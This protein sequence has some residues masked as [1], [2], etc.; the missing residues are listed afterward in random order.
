M[1]NQVKNYLLFFLVLAVICLNTSFLWA[2]DCQDW[3][4]TNSRHVSASRAYTGTDGGCG[5]AAGGCNTSEA[6]TAYYAVGSDDYLGT[7]PNAVTVLRTEDGGQSYRRGACAATTEPTTLAYEAETA[8]IGNGV[9]ES[10]HPGYSGSGYVNYANEMGSYVEWTVNTSSSGNF[11]VTFRYA[12]GGTSSRPMDIIVNDDTQI[13]SQSFNATGTWAD[14][15]ELT[16]A[17]Y[18]DRGL[19]SI[20]AASSSSEGGPNLDKIDVAGNVV[21]TPE[22]TYTGLFVS[23]N[24]NDNNPGTISA[25]FKSITKAQSVASPGTTVYLRG[26]TYRGFRIAGSDANYNFVHNI[27]KSGIT[28]SAYPGETPVFDFTGTTTAKRVAAFHIAKGVNVTLIGFHV[29]GV[30]VGNNKQAECFRIEGNAKFEKM[31]CRD[32]QANG[33]YFTTDASGSCTNCDSYNN[34]GVGQSA[35]NTDGFGAHCRGEV[36]FRYCRAWNCSDDGYDCIA[37]YSRVTFDHCWVYNINSTGDGNGFK[38]GGWGTATPPASVPSHIVRY[39]LAANVKNSGFY[40]NHHPGKSADWTYNTAYNC[41]PD[42]NMLERVSTRNATDIPGTREVL[43]YNIAFG[44]TPTSNMNLPAANV[45]DNSWTKR[46]VTVTAAD[47]QSTDARQMI[48][49]RNADGSLPAITFMKL[50]NGSDLAGM[51][52]AP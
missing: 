42:F 46:G 27:T 30:P 24:G 38:V 41:H 20:K 32:N 48:R 16:V 33:F 45:T 9:I 23:P 5:G 25:P 19:N 1:E 26:G 37:T 50:A 39:C 7:S 13:N 18:L 6:A 52:Y 11:D 40:A 28:Y 31:T 35:G 2:D 12:N 17:V 36:A 15:T 43:H 3:T 49:P 44:G 47:F 8:V 51:G 22:P 21:P 10:E 34:I 29:T 14:W 4:A